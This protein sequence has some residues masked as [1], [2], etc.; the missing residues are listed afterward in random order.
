MHACRRIKL[1]ETTIYGPN[2]QSFGAC[3]G[4]LMEGDNSGVF[5]QT[6]REIAMLRAKILMQMAHSRVLVA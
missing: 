4:A 5:E 6:R 1:E 2:L 3:S